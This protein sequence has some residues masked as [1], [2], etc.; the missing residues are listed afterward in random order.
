MRFQGYG[1]L[2]NA[3]ESPFLSA[4]GLN[5]CRRLARIRALK[6][7]LSC[8][9]PVLPGGR[10]LS[11]NPGGRTLDSGEEFGSWPSHAKERNS[12]EPP[13]LLFRWGFDAEL[14]GWIR[15]KGST[16]E[17][18]RGW[19]TGVKYEANP[20]NRLEGRPRTGWSDG[21]QRGPSSLAQVTIRFP[22][23][24]LHLPCI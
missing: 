5:V 3:E 6:T 14:V 19:G 22:I 11:Q 18:S 24:R 16:P 17:R 20:L 15:S 1:L 7:H 2:S 13:F 21:G 4:L 23:L 12:T 8:F 10:V 9:S